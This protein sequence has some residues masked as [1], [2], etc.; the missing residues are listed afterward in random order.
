MNDKEA[1]C[2]FIQQTG[3]LLLSGRRRALS[4]LIIHPPLLPAQCALCLISWQWLQ[5]PQAHHH[6]HHHQQQ[7]Q[8]YSAAFQTTLLAA[9]TAPLQTLAG[10]SVRHSHSLGIFV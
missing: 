8:P 9:A 1:L 2:T 3:Y 6:H 4:K 10:L 7:Q 5:Q